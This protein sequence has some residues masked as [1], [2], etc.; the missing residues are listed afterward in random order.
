MPSPNIPPGY[1]EQMDPSSVKFNTWPS[2]GVPKQIFCAGAYGCHGNRNEKSQTKSMQGSHHADDSVLQFGSIVQASQGLT[3]G[4][5]YRFLSGVKGGE[6]SDWE[7]DISTVN[8]NEYFGKE[9]VDNPRPAL[10]VTGV[11]SMS[12]FC[13]SCHG[14]FHQY[15][16]GVADAGISATAGAAMSPWIRHPTDIE[17]PN[18]GEYSSYISYDVYAPVAR[19]T[20]PSAASPDGRVPAKPIV[21]CLSCHRGHAS[22][23]WD[24]LKFSYGQMTTGNSGAGAGTG[25]FACHGDKDGI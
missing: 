24:S 22:R 25:C 6:A 13:A 9:L 8:H 10:P 23:Y 11:E 14:N 16:P 3:L 2:G 12:E 19:T 18:S 21:F 5:S 15:N 1:V 4:T 20:I 17:L 7:W